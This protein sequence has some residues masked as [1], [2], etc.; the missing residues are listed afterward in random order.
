MCNVNQTAENLKTVDCS[1][2]MNNGVTV[3]ESH[4]GEAYCTKCMTNERLQKTQPE[5]YI[6][7]MQGMVYHVIDYKKLSS[8]EIDGI[9]MADY[10]DFCDA[11]ISYAEYNGVPMTDEQLENL[12]NDKGY[13]A[14]VNETIF[15]QM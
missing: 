8:V 15:N 9:D 6:K 2:C 13:S 7:A 5:L 3:V 1:D 10:G 4:T 11:Y 12:A 14:F